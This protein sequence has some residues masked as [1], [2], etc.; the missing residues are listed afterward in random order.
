MKKTD[1][2]FV[3]GCQSHNHS[4]KVRAL[5]AAHNMTTVKRKAMEN[6]FKPAPATVEEVMNS[7][8]CLVNFPLILS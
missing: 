7:T 1:G 8:K 2:N 4:P 3:S 6:I 5:Q